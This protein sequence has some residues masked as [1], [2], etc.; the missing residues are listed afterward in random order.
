VRRGRHSRDGGP[1]AAGA[2]ALPF[3][4]LAWTSACLGL[5]WLPL[6]RDL[7]PWV[8]AAVGAAI[9][10]RLVLATRGGDAPPAAIRW[11]LALL[12]I[13]LLFVEFRTFNG[14]AAG[15]ALLG[16][17]A[18]LKILEARSARDLYV[19]V[20]IVYFLGVAALLAGGGFWMLGYLL[21][22]CWLTAAALLRIDG[23]VRGL[24]A[25]TALAYSARVL[26]HALPLALAMWL[27]FPRLAAP[28]WRIGGE[29]RGAVSGL[30]D[31]LSPGDL[32]DL[33]LSDDIAFRAHFI[34]PTPSRGALYWRGPVLDEFDGRA[35]RRHDRGFS[36][37]VPGRSAYH[38]RLELEPY[39]H[40][41]I[42][43]LDRPVSAALPGA[44]LSGDGVLVRPGRDSAPATL[45]ASSTTAPAG[46][47]PLDRRVRRLDTRLPAGSN[48]RSRA[49][50]RLLHREY[51]ADV[52]FIAAILARFHRD[53]Y[54]Y[55][56]TPPPLLGR[57]PVDEFLFDTKRG[58]CGHY[59]SAFAVLARAAGI[60]ARVVTGYFGGT[61]NPFDGDWVVRQSD[62]HAWDEVWIAGRGWLRVDPTAAIAPQ[63][64]DPSLRDGS[65]TPGPFAVAIG[66]D[67]PWLAAFALRLDAL[68]TLWR[69]RILAYGPRA[70]GALLTRLHVPGPDAAGLAAMLAAALGLSFVW[71]A[72]IARRQ[73][74]TRSRD[75]LQRAFGKLTAKVARAGVV[76]FPY[77][78]PEDYAR[79]VA[80][81]CPDLGPTVEKL[82]R[83]YASLR[84]GA[85]TA[86]DRV[87]AFGAA[88][89]AFR[90]RGS[91]ASAG[92][93]RRPSAPRSTRD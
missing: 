77:E 28:L 21:A 33:A 87:R 19:V 76:R 8:S 67:A 25:R 84:Y 49:L 71:L 20:L 27:F 16:L 86:D 17:T 75:E 65:R 61:F 48:P 5:V 93:R 22:V 29:G 12:A 63:R 9:G 90:P 54:Y 45:L 91:R 92:I 62:A 43:A 88:V 41:W 53:P 81:L 85:P 38:Y 57:N 6:A 32:D 18:G 30:G 37:T 4:P 80:A 52:Q 14:L 42:Y 56:L 73:L 36:R 66:R 44:V 13:A 23:S 50:A 24:G 15:T 10:A 35:W 59:A 47:S 55:T 7:P 60:P 78:G 82:C 34:G 68:R 11:P 79:R 58:F 1:A 70:Q 74:R 69:E 51:P 39:R 31:T 46:A 3:G 83:E 64:V 40:D 72:W 2:S 89:R 26:L